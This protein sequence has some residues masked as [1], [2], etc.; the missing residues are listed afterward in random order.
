[1]K[2]ILIATIA[3]LTWSAATAEEYPEQTIKDQC[4]ADFPGDFFLQSGCVDLQKSSFDTLSAGVSGIPDD[5]ATQILGKCEVDFGQDFFL[6][7]GCIDLQ[8]DSWRSLNQ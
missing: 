5:I 1:M 2:R 3:T 4:A 7:K 6:R 8:A